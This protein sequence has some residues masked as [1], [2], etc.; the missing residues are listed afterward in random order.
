M[1]DQETQQPTSESIK[2]SRE[3][4]LTEGYIAWAEDFQVNPDPLVEM[5]V[6]DN[7]KPSD[8]QTW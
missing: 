6:N 4:E 8:E 3:Q 7:L 2:T 1:N 5:D